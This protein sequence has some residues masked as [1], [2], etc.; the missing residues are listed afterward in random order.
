MRQMQRAADIL[1]RMLIGYPAMCLRLKPKKSGYGLLAKYSP[2]R[3]WTFLDRWR[4]LT[5]GF[6]V[7]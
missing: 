4:C 6:R 5:P 1:S 2:G 7:P 3:P